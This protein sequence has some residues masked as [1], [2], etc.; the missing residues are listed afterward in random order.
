MK[1][2]LSAVLVVVSLSAFAEEQRTTIVYGQD[3]RQDVNEVKDQRIKLLGK[4]VAGRIPNFSFERN[5][6]E[7]KIS[8]DN[9]QTLSS[10]M[11][12]KVCSGERFAE[13]ATAAD[14]TGFLVGEDLLVT[15][16]HCM[17]GMGQ[18]IENGYSRQC[19]NFSWM[20]DYTNDSDL[21]NVSMDNV[22]GCS[23]IVAGE[24]THKMD[25]A[26][27]KLDRKVTGRTPLK[28][29]QNK[30]GLGEKIFVMGHPSGL[31]LKYADGA[32][33]F[34][35]EEHYFST[36]LDT[37]GGNSGSP[38]FNAKTLEV[39]GILV[40]GD[41]DYVMSFEDNGERCTKVN[42]CDDEREN[43]LEDDT[44]ILGEHVNFIEVVNQ[45]L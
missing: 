27:I 3:N 39:E 8:F 6:E 37:F 43:C 19:Q 25:Y 41:T 17:M 20:F 26:L 9:V 14:C 34:E 2:L 31:P 32:R 21:K 22:Y 13:Q 12:M 36:N 30:V 38:V 35:T 40:R 45:N 15:A 18:T 42:I 11:S 33:V 7:N 1:K 5:E 16:G 10:P 29:A 24:F 28:L 23:L 44:N 4:S